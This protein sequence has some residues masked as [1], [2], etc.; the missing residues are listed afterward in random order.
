MSGI[1]RVK[2]TVLSGPES[3]ESSGQVTID[4]PSYSRLNGNVLSGR[5]SYHSGT[6][7]LNDVVMKRGTALYRG[8]GSIEGLGTAGEA[9]PNIDAHLDIKG[10][11]FGELMA[12]AGNG[13]LKNAAAPAGKIDGD[14]SIT[15]PT[16][17]IHVDIKALTPSLSYGKSRLLTAMK[18]KIDEGKVKLAGLRLPGLS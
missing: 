17:S 7:A 1:A 2:G 14:V 16:D 8:Y 18:L 12:M 4:S 10:E 9:A 3:V 5:Y 6:L 13:L 15:G 11:K